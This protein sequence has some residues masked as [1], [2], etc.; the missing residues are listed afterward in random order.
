MTNFYDS[1]IG[2]TYINENEVKNAS[3]KKNQAKTTNIN[4][5]LDSTI[6]TSDLKMISITGEITNID[7]YEK[8][9]SY[10][11]IILKYENENKIMPDEKLIE[12]Y[13]LAFNLADYAFEFFKKHKDDEKVV[14]FSKASIK[15][16]LN[17]VIETYD[18][19]KR[20]CLISSEGKDCNRSFPKYDNLSR[21]GTFA[22]GCHRCHHAKGYGAKRVPWVDDFE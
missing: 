14:F 16:V 10:I 2:A 21:R 11:N 5:T 9:I 1:V 18:S 15:T 8:V 17:A 20:N 4:K 3:N 7:I 19:F 22:S 13:R 6:S 12:K